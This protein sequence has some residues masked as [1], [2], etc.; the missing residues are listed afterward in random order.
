MSQNVCDENVLVN[1]IEDDMNT[2]S[3]RSF[4]AS[5]AALSLS[6]LLG[7]CSSG[8]GSN[9]GASSS[10]LERIATQD[11]IDAAKKDKELIVYGSC[12]E[13]YLAVVCEKFKELFGIDAQFQ[14]MSTGEVQAKIE[15]ENGHPSGDVWFGGTTDP[16]NIAAAKGLL[17]PYKARNDSHLMASRYKDAQDMWHGIYKGSLGFFY[18]SDEVKRLN[19]DVPKD[20]PDL[21]DPKYKGLIWSSNY[22]T[23]GT[24]KLICNT[25]IQKYGHDKGIQYLVDLDKNIAVYTK[26]GAG[27]A[28]N[29]GTGE[30]ILGIGFLS[31]A[32]EQIVSN[33]YTNISLITPSSGSG[34][35]IGA[36]AIMKGCKHLDAA[37]LW[38]EFALSPQCVNLAQTVGSNQFLVIDDGQQPQ[39]PLDLGLDPS[40]D[41]LMEYDFEDAKQNTEKY[42]QEV[43]AALH[44]GDD[45]F[46]K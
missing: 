37:K 9:G 30:C 44:G 20:W 12:D 23:A 5:S 16:Y 38:V 46:K 45:R 21:L 15:E 13:P 4:L 27:P 31:Q 1:R 28:K 18:N 42:V 25:A 41:D 34:Y 36:T 35:E 14:R 7:G 17:E 39:A 29:V 22:Y 10:D 6:A 3:R 26:S 33:G 43:M 32:I 2:L 24:A 11:V 8:A 19:L 40:F